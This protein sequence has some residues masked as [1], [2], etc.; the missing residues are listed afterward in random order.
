MMKF[1]SIPLGLFL[2]FVQIPFFGEPPPEKKEE[3]SP[4]KGW[5]EVKYFSIAPTRY[6]KARDGIIKAESVGSRSTLFKVVGEKERNLSILSWRWKVSNVVR[7]AIETKKDRFDAAA[8]V[9]VIFGRKG[10]FRGFG[11]EPSGLR[12]EYIWAN[13]LPKG[14]IFEH[15]EDK[16]CKVFVLEPG[17]GKAEK[18]VYEERN[19]HK[20]FKLAFGTEPPGISAI[21][22]QTDT[23]QSNEMVTAY[24]S[25]PIL[26][27]K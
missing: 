15:P 17:E 7:S 27:K 2:I 10:S 1:F 12:I 22:I 23:D 3:L 9:M 6:S 4:V 26:K 20:D 25:E 8:R 19:I 21:G 24:Y 11:K 16:N 14:H 5:W 18:W 13:R